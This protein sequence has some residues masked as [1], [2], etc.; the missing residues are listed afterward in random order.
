MCCYM[1]Y[2]LLKPRIRRNM[3]NI[4]YYPNVLIIYFT[5]FLKYLNQKKF[6]WTVQW[7]QPCSASFITITVSIINNRENPW[8][9]YRNICAIQKS[10]S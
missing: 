3:L 7:F 6:L 8:I 9:D 4:K 5:D 1:D 2:R 10:S